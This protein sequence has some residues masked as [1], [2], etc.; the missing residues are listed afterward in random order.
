MDLLWKVD[1]VTLL[2]PK[3]SLLELMIRGTVMYGVVFVLLRL[4]LRRQVGGIAMPDILV[5]VLIAEIAGNGISAGY[6]SVVEGTVLIG[7]VLFWSFLFEWLQFRFPRIERLLRDRQLKLI[8]NGHLLHR[9]MRA[10]FVTHEE[11]MSQLRLN[12]IDNYI[13]VKA[14]YMEANGKISVIRYNA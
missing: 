5:I 12:G 13:E 6:E 11:L 2:E 10:E 1:W 9:N 8:E 7:T 14:A 3:R 4:D